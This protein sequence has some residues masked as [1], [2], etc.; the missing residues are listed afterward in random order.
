MAY[1][2]S[3]RKPGPAAPRLIRRGELLTALDRAAE[4]KVTLISAPAGSGKTS[5]LRAW[6]DGPGQRYRLAVVQVRRDQL[7]AQQFWLA[8]L[9]A[10][11]QASGRSGQ[12]EQLAATPDFN[13]A[14][15]TGRVLSELAEH[16][17]RTF[18]I[19]ISTSWPRR[20]RSTQLSR[21]LESCPS[22]CTRSS[23]PG[24]T[25]RSGCTS[26]AWRAN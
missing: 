5:L 11:R 10:I 9:G 7:D 16:H 21:L 15:I 23:P 14:T 6:A 1:R 25:C 22:M 19:M 4:A 13:E 20:K 17:E 26:C 12:G 24:A 8:V 18:L 3:P 2:T